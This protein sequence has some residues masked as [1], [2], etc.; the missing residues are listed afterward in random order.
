MNDEA[1]ADLRPLMVPRLKAIMQTGVE[2]STVLDVGIQ[3]GTDFLI[4]C[5]P[6]VPHVLF[7]PVDAY[8][9]RIRERYAALRYE[10]I[11]IA[12]S[13]D[14]RAAWQVGVSI[15]Y[16]GRVTH[17]WLS[18]V[19]ISAAEV[20]TVVECKPVRRMRLDMVMTELD[21]VGPFLL[22][23]DV[24]GQELEVL[25]GATDTLRRVSVL[26]VET[27][28]DKLREKLDFAESSGFRLIEI[29]DPCYYYGLLSQMDLI[30]VN[31]DWVSRC[32]DL[33]PWQSKAFSWDAWHNFA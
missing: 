1:R 10:L 26:I 33:T 32:P 3:K 5:F 23:I 17:S 24:D 11:P 6:A 22:K 27:T 19:A 12:L 14:D 29:V 2:V 15:D 13:N 25:Q 18:D 16:S 21:H 8:F 28:V 9:D 31:L 20:A 4:A 30:L 7:E